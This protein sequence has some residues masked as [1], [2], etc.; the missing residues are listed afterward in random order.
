M[1]F[2]EI[3]WERADWNYLAQTREQRQAVVNMVMRYWVP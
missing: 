3:M 2:K 1:E